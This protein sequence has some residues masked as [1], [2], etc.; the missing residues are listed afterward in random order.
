[1][2]KS[3]LTPQRYA[4]LHAA[5]SLSLDD[6]LGTLQEQLD[7]LRVPVTPTAM[8]PRPPKPAPEL[9]PEDLRFFNGYGGFLPEGSAYVMHLAAGLQTPAPWCNYLCR[10]G[11]GT[12]CCESGLLFT[13]GDNSHR[14][15]LTPWVN[16]PVT[17]LGGE[18]LLVEDLD[19]GDMFS[20]TRLPLG[21][22]PCLPM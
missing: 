14:R 21:Q 10:P 16:D 3:T 20:P 13:Y 2:D 19:T 8:A 15:R 1:M 6:R 5:A 18:Y 17:P 22:A 9:P 12:L 7:A 4:L 11:F